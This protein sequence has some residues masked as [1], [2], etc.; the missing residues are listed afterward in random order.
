MVLRRNPEVIAKRLDNTT[1]LVDL[2]T[3]RIFE[4]NETGTRIW[5]L[6]GEGR[7]ADSIMRHLVDEFEVD[8]AQAE[9]E[10]NN[11]LARLRADGLLE[12]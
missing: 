9:G 5:E 10:V 12:K 8:H 6:L 7:D 4:L 1:V 2:P 11:L 3:S